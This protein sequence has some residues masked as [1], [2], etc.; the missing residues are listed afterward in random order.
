MKTSPIEFQLDILRFIAQSRDGR[1]Y[2]ESLDEDF[3][4]QN[5]HATVFSLLRDFYR[6]FGGSFS[7]GNI[8][9]HLDD[10]I[11]RK[12]FDLTPEVKEL[13][14]DTITD[15]F[16]PFQANSDHI[17]SKVIE[18][19]QIKL[20]KALI[21][22]NAL[23]VQTANGE[24]VDDIYKEIA[25][26]KRIGDDGLDEDAN[27][28][29]F[30]IADYQEGT[31]DWVEAHPT[32][33]NS[34]NR[35]TGL[36]GFYSPQLIIFMGGPKSFKTGTLLNIAVAY[37]R[38]GYNVYY[39][40]AENGQKQIRDRA[41]QAMLHTTSKEL[42]SGSEDAVLTQIVDKF[43]H[44]G[45]DF[46]ADYFPAHTKTMNDVEAELEYLRDTYNWIP[47]I[48]CYDYLDLFVPIDRRI[49]EKRLQI[50][51]VYH[52]AIRLQKKWQM[53]GFT[54]SQVSRQ[55]VGKTIIDMTDFAE[56]FGKA[57][58][59]HAAFALCRDEIEEENNL[60]RIVPVAQREGVRGSMGRACF[61]EIYEDKM[62]LTEI[63]KKEWETRYNEAAR[64]KKDLNSN[65]EAVRRPARKKVR[66]TDK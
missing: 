49:K 58:N 48:I 3:F 37:A 34:L 42:R 17:R 31:M 4:T 22:E 57:A 14:Q 40:D 11:A 36:G 61:V 60:M 38:D 13:L 55:A 15:V 16:K 8:L 35:L 30:L 53:F 66:I 27:R 32:Y 12:S 9:Q 26:I 29:E 28:G 50:Q 20:I 47:D 56:D 7:L 45:G 63:S 54:L 10:E 6:E 62:Q 65:G 39:A 64:A 41:R 59:C 5:E 51:A 19:Y 52:D 33:L 25:R 24:L 1:K 46:R 18:Q 2:I 21:K 43:K 44:Y 23:K